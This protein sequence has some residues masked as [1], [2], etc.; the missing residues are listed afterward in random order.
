MNNILDGTKI[1][2][3]T[4]YYPEHWPEQMWKQDLKRMKE[5]GIEVIR[6]AEFS[7]NLTEPVEGSYVYDFW[8]DFL[9]LCEKEEMKVIFCT[10]TA[11]PPAWLTEKHPDVLNALQDGTLLRHG[12]RR[13]YNYN[14]QTYRNYVS[15]IVQ[16]LAEHY[17]KRPCIVG[18]QI[19]NEINCE[20][21]LFFSRADDDAFRKWVRE[22]YETLDALNDAW[23]TRF[24]NQTYSSFDEIHVPGVTNHM[25]GNPHQKLDYRRFISDSARSF[26]KLQ[27]DIISKYKKPDDFTD[28]IK[29]YIDEF[30]VNRHERNIAELLDLLGIE[31]DVDLKATILA[32]KEILEDKRNGK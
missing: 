22:K 26:V 19:D 18:W 15:I 25:A 2:I 23:G 31:N 9:D 6:V 12:E 10:P 11:T 5:T 24:W 7:W 14:S 3:G 27:S 1:T 28:V 4:C 8:D 16:K 21:D 32:I 20:T 29:A 30:S 13:H 17:G